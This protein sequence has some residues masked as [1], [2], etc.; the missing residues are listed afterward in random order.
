M[1]TYRYAELPAFRISDGRERRLVHTD[2]LMIV[3][4]DVTDGRAAAPDPYHSHPHEQVS[5]VAEGEVNFL[6][7]GNITRLSPGD[8]YSV[9]PDIP[10]AIQP[11]SPRVR[12]IDCFT[13][14]RQ[15]FL[16]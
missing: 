15:D 14:I 16:K 7:E 11:L 9:P 3:V 12:L 10:H 4:L 5:Y 1:P 8:V 2:H 6:M 13:P